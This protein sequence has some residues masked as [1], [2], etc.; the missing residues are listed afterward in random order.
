MDNDSFK[1][2][3]VPPFLRKVGK[4]FLRHYNTLR[5]RITVFL[6]FVV[7]ASAFWFFRALGDNYQAENI[8]LIEFINLPKNKIISGNPTDRIK[9]RVKGSGFTI[10]N[11]KIKPPVIEVNVNEFSLGRQAIDSLNLFLVTRY[12]RDLFLNEINKNNI[13]PLEIISISPDTLKLNFSRTKTRKIAV[14]ASLADNKDMFE[15]QFIQ[16]GKIRVEPDSIVVIG[17]AAIVDPLKGGYTE[18]VIFHNLKDSVTKKVRLQ[19]I[20]G[21]LISSEKVKITVPVDRFTESSFNISLMTK[22]VPDSLNLKPF[23][24]NVKVN[25]RVSL[26]KYNLVSETDFR[27]Y[28]DYKEVKSAQTADSR[29]KVYIDSLPDYIH[30]VTLYPGSV[31]FLIEK[32]DAQNRTDRRDW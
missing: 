13:I 21:V 22:Y 30:S 16:N 26:S 7:L 3:N 2:F 15:R 24:R 8:Y 32:N 11:H 10:L 31:E 12:S 14:I 20:Q 27:P 25:Y 6:L 1:D 18:K 28:V 23:P 29:I 17:P 19:E 9:V 5:Q 4:F